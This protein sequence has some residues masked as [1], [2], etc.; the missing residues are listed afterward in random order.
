MEV[1]AG[2]RAIGNHAD[3]AGTIGNFPRFTDR[4]AGRERFFVK[5]FQISPAPHPLLEN[6][7]EREWIEHCAS[8]ERKILTRNGRG[9]FGRLLKQNWLFLDEMAVR[10]KLIVSLL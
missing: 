9:L 2:Q 1:L 3:I 5:T 7:P 8:L 6:W 4:N 10:A